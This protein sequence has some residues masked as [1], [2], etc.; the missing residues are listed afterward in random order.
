MV[1]LGPM[2]KK[3]PLL[4]RFQLVS[5]GSVTSSGQHREEEKQ[6]PRP[7]PYV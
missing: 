1:P 3:P 4:T 5:Q 6:K 7:H 2:G